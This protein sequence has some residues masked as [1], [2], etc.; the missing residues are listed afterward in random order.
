MYYCP[1]HKIEELLIMSKIEKEY[2][3]FDENSLLEPYKLGQVINAYDEI[4][5]FRLRKSAEGVYDYEYIGDIH[6]LWTVSIK[7]N[8]VVRII[9]RQNFPIPDNKFWDNHYSVIRKKLSEKSKLVDEDYKGNKM[10][11]VVRD[12][13]VMLIFLNIA[14]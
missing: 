14:K 2:W 3:T 13:F 9:Y 6:F 7:E 12:G 8:I 10:F 4:T 11:L 1:Y 5:N